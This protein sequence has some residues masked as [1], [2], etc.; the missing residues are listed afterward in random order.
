MKKILFSFVLLSFLSCNNKE[1]EVPAE[2]P[3]AGNA[4]T[5]E[6]LPYTASYTSNWSSNVSDAD[7]KTVLQ[8][9]K[10]WADGNLKGLAAAMGDTVDVDMSNGVSLHVTRDSLMKMWTTYRDSLSSVSIDM[11]TWHKMYAVDK[12]DAAVVTWYKEIDTYKT[13]KV[14]SAV[15]HDINMMKNGKIIWYSQ[16]KRP[17]LPKKK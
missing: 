15:Y 8:S 2:T 6:G 1:K 12:K 3:K 4:D 16:Y 9:Y 13:G 14:D 11:A 5:P 17:L 7:L 10:D